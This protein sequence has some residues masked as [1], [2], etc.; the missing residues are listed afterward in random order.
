M[1]F[2]SLEDTQYMDRMDFHYPE[3]EF[4]TKNDH[5]ESETADLEQTFSSLLDQTIN[6]DGRPAANLN[7]FPR[8]NQKRQNSSFYEY[9]PI[10]LSYVQKIPKPNIKHQIENSRYEEISTEKTQQD[11]L[12]ENI[13]N[14]LK[15]YLYEL[16]NKKYNSTTS[17]ST[18]SPP[19][20]S[21]ELEHFPHY[22]D[23]SS[24][25]TKFFNKNIWLANKKKKINKFKKLFSLFTIVQFNNTQCM[26][27]S[28]AGSYLG[29]CFTD[30][31]CDDLGGTGVGDCANGYGV[32]CVCKY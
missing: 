27:T 17:T 16:Y 29:L 7:R 19:T 26:A 30:G 12:T 1:S 13:N 23:S 3:V 15:N 20:S 32:C 24:A 9:K 31:E 18:I 4:L 28:N 6:D 11:P 25:E 5:I 10:R 22:G 14:L 21:S 2:Q 8:L